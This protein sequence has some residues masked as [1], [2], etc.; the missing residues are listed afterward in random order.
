MYSLSEFSYELPASLIA[1]QPLA[2]R[3]QAKLLVVS[4]DTGQIH[5]DR[6]GNIGRYLPKQSLLVLND[7]RV[8]PARIFGAKERTGGKV[9]I[10]LLRQLYDG[11]S[12]E[13]L[14]R[15]IGRI[16]AGEKIVFAGSRMTATV[17]DRERRIVRFSG[18]NIAPFLRRCGHVPLPPYIRRDDTPADRRDYQTVYARSSGSVAA[19]T[20]GL[21]FTKGLLGTLKKQGHGTTVVTL[22]VNYATFKPVFEPDV[23][24]HRMHTESYFVRPAAW[25]QILSARKIGRKIVAVGTTSCRVL[26]TVANGGQLAGETD[27][28]I[29]PGISFKMTDCLITN[30]HM[31]FSTLLMLV[32]AFGGTDLMRRVYR[33]AI[34]KEYR[35]FSYGDGM[36]IL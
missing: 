15:P 22:H 23:R 32:Y 10:F 36:L 3:D 24:D 21:H 27:I 35:F 6:F 8:I 17:T 25:Q 1:Q 29:Y 4:R 31:P 12:F 5:H 13:T 2:R 16:L 11:H 26:E 9:E 14:L 33:E 30:F 7:T 20:A 34:T 18:K 19:P 28:F